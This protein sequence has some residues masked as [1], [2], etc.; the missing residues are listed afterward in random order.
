M[1][2][3]ENHKLRPKK[4]SNFV[5]GYHAVMEAL[6]NGKSFEKIFIQK[7]IAEEKAK[8][9]SKKSRELAIPVSRVP[10]EKLNRI[11]RKNHQGIIGFG[12]PIEYQPLEQLIPLIY[13]KGESPFFVIL[14]EVTDVRNFGAIA[15]TAEA[16]GVHALII[17]LKRSANVN[18][19]AIKT[20]AGVLNY[21][22]VCRVHS[23]K[24]TVQFLKE[25]GIQL[26]AC[27]EKGEDDLLALKVQGPRAIV[28]GSE[29]NG[30][31]P[32]LLKD[33]DFQTRISMPGKIQ[34]L[35]VSVAAGIVIHHFSS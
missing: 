11:S 32:N 17:P 18:E 8:S 25:S 5:Y 4:K 3:R 6:E 21:L 9:V 22:P 26:I 24:E 12:S 16:M 35:N 15:R 30:I 23:L 2:R 7:G 29:E 27:T 14:D 19:D 33:C 10:I 1:E 34:S 28:L 13:E 31:H 20:S